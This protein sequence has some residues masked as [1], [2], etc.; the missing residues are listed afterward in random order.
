MTIENGIFT[1]HETW[2]SIDF[3][4]IDYS[5]LDSI[6][7]KTNF[8]R[9]NGECELV[10]FPEI[11]RKIANMRKN[12]DAFI[13]SNNVKVRKHD[14]VDVKEEVSAFNVIELFMEQVLPEFQGDVKSCL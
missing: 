3:L 7:C 4:N 11:T 8:V 13:V 2:N 12:S 5:D 1:F 6:L 9:I 10:E 14:S